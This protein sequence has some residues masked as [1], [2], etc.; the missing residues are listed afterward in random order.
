MTSI[1]SAK[2]LLEKAVDAVTHYAFNDADLRLKHSVNG[3]LT[4]PLDDIRYFHANA[5]NRKTFD[6]NVARA[7]KAEPELASPSLP[8]IGMVNEARAFYTAVEEQ[9]AAEKNRLIEKRAAIAKKR[10]KTAHLGTDLSKHEQ[11][12]EATYKTLLAALEP[13]RVSVE[14]HYVESLT[15]KLHHYTQVIKQAGGLAKAF[16]YSKSF[17]GKVAMRQNL[18][19]DFSFFFKAGG[20]VRDHYTTFTTHSNV[21]QLIAAKALELSHAEVTSFS[22][23]LAGKI[24]REANGKKLI[25]AS[26]SGITLWQSSILRAVLS[27]DSVQVWN[28]QIIW[29]RSCLGTSFNQWPTRQ[30]N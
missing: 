8:F 19:H 28:T 9:T 14:Q 24:D 10:A 2:R 3:Y 22:G 21:K 11:A 7:I 23:K 17:C 26:V 27:D 30:A 12:S 4:G 5:A 18:P 6:K 15:D 13:V 16:F 29:N 1:S 25:T 20:W